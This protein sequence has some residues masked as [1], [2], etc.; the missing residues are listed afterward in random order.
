VP[1]RLLHPA[2]V[3]QAALSAMADFLRALGGDPR[4]EIDPVPPMLVK[5]LR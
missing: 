3:A 2:G 5:N 1:L 4:A